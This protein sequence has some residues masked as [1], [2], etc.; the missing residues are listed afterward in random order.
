MN[1][2]IAKRVAVSCLAAGLTL[3]VGCTECYRNVVDPCY[4]ERYGYKARQEVCQ[5]F[6]AQVYNGHVLEQTVWN[7][8]FEPGTDKLTPAGLEHLAYLARRRPVPDTTLYLQT[9]QDIVYDPAAA[10]KFV[11]E[12]NTLDSKRV[13]AIQKY[14]TAQTASRP[15]PFEVVVHDPHEVGMAA[16]AANAAIQA[17]NTTALTVPTIIMTSAPGRF[18]GTAG[19]AGIA[20]GR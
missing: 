7:T 11:E 16:M 3:C 8:H 2:L 17:R 4:P 10:D 19:A 9:A 15:L 1:G 14:L 18:P 6:V 13:Q 20:I 12:R 5:P